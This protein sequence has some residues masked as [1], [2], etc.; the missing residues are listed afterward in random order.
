[1]AGRQDKIDH[2]SRHRARAI[3]VAPADDLYHHGV[4][5]HAPARDISRRVE[6]NQD[7]QPRSG[8]IHFARMDSGAWPCTSVRLGRHIHS[9]DRF[10]LDSKIAEAET[11]C[12]L[13]SVAYMGALDHRRDRPL[14]LEH[15]SVA[16]ADCAAPVGYP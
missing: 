9:G 13:V 6:P 11:V 16:L 10:L 1:M 7:Q 8:R 4:D 5:I 3:A 14:V 12:A 2:G 15:L